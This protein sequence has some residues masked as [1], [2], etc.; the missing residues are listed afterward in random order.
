MAANECK[1]I[2]DKEIMAT[3]C[4][5]HWADRYPPILNISQVAEML[6]IPKSTLYLWSSQ[7]RL[8]GCS[9]KAGRRL[10]FFRDRV[11][12]QIFNSGI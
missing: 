12:K 6:D 10:L 5:T 2:S 7:G 8:K 11:I 9:R 3:F 1:N 4:D